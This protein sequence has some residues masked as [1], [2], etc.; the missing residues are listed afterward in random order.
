MS[1]HLK[2]ASSYQHC[3]TASE[4]V[5]QPAIVSVAWKSEIEIAGGGRH[6]NRL[7]FLS[8]FKLLTISFVIV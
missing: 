6:R 5:D 2:Y 8:N 7:H 1:F 4:V 3:Y